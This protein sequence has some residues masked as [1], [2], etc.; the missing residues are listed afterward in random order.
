MKT[1]QCDRALL[2]GI[3]WLA[4]AAG[5]ARAATITETVPFTIQAPAASNLL[6]QTVNVSTPQFNPALGTFESGATTIT[7]TTGIA[8]E[9]FNT[10]AGG[11]YDIL[12]SDTLSVGGIPGLFIEELTGTIPADQPAFIAPAATFPFGPV[13]RSDPA[14]AVVGAGTWNQLF[15]LPFPSLTIK[16]GPA[17]VLPAI[18]ISG[19]SV[20]T[21]T[22]TPATA[23]VP[24]P[25]S[26]CALAFLLGFGFVAKKMRSRF[27]RLP[28]R[29][30]LPGMRP[31]HPQAGKFARYEGR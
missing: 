20:T 12:L 11:P 2:A 22:Y 6:P 5:A 17:A 10:G 3:A 18:I 14:E 8:L 16:E 23:A 25:R 21:Y 30:P 7:G 13:D 15:S 4:F 19:S 9:F 27:F 26:F 24:E 1:A 28:S 31:Q 29:N